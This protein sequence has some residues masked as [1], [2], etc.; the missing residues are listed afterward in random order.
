MVGFLVLSQHVSGLKDPE[1]DVAGN[2]GVLQMFGLCK[3]H[4]KLNNYFLQGCEFGSKLSFKK[5]CVNRRKKIWYKNAKN[6]L[7][8]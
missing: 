4:T 3:K 2:A 5:E 8:S 7:F 1:A 6:L